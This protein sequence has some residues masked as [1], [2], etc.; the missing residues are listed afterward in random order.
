V[1]VS[2][3]RERF[4][5]H[6][7]ILAER[8]EK[9][10]AAI[11]FDQMS[12]T[13]TESMLEIHVDM[14]SELCL[15]FLEH[16]YHGSML[17]TGDWKTEDHPSSIASVHKLLDLLVIADEYLLPT[18]T[19]EC[20]M[21]LLSSDPKQCFC[22]SCTKQPYDNSIATFQVMGPATCI[23]VKT[24]LDIL[25]VI[26]HMRQ[27]G[28]ATSFSASSSLSVSWEE[29]SLW[30][31]ASKHEMRVD[32][33]DAISEAVNRYIL[34]N[35]NEVMQQHNIIDNGSNLDGMEEANQVLLLSLDEYITSPIG[36]D[37]RANGRT[38]LTRR[39]TTDDK[40]T[41]SPADGTMT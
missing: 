17:S 7:A 25:A 8:S 5:A 38:N 12:K 26:Q 33:L 13:S 6:G 23:N 32:A 24:C 11:R 40:A 1:I 31:P 35:F 14:S 34:M 9:L 37:G 28:S 21:R 30:G 29:T 16:I 41:S 15:L 4:F 2:E 3:D 22:R 39:P 10:G 36:A 19:Q 18:L 27:L 20:A